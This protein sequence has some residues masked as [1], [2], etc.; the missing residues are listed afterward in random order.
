MIL[1]VV[2]AGWIGE[3]QICHLWVDWS[4]AVP[5]LRGPYIPAWYDAHRHWHG[6]AWSLTGLVTGAGITWLARQISSQVL[7]QEAMGM[8]DITLM[9][10]IGSFVGWQAVTLVFLLAPL[11]GLLAGIVIRLL[12]GKTY[13]PYGPWLS[14]AAVAVLFTW[15]RLWEQ[16]RMIFSDWLSVAALATI[17]GGGFVLL[18]SLIRLYKSIPTRPNTGS[19]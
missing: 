14:M 13:L 8:G 9:A 18:L 3:V 15:T 19:K 7:A 11:T 17:G 5:Q 1:G 16:T 12:S 4:F 10:M 2:A 6:I